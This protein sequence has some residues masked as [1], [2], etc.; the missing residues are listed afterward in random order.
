M[1]KIL[2]ADDNQEMLVT[3]SRIFSFHQFEVETAHNGLEAIEMARKSKPDLII[4]DGKMPEMDGFEACKVLK[5][6]SDTR[7]IPVIFLTAQYTHPEQR[8]TGLELG[9][10]DYMLKPFNS[11]E[12]VARTKAVLRRTELL[13]MLRDEN[14]RLADNNSKIR[15]ELNELL[16]ATRKGEGDSFIDPLTGLYSNSFFERRLQEEF[17]R[18]IRHKKPLSLVIVQM[19]QME[20]IGEKYG[21]QVSHYIMMKCANALLTHTRV[22]DVLA[23]NSDDKYF[24]LLPETDHQG[25]YLEAERVRIVLQTLDLSGDELLNTLNINQR[26]QNEFQNLSFSLGS[27][28]FDPNETEMDD[29]FELLHQ[30][31]QALRA[32]IHQ[33]GNRLVV[34]QTNHTEDNQEE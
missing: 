19:H 14:A 30:A 10:E 22:S 26:Q 34:F 1:P 7:D 5:S 23:S 2:V 17:L 28:T 4:L 27:S 16:K 15:G 13:T 12:L 24:I 33:G 25:T 9:A 18:T 32:A 8:V 20:R 21:I 29:Q 3:L 6:K 11:R 31:D